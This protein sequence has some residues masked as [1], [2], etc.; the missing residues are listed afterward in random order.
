MNEIEV[1]ENEIE[2]RELERTSPI[3]QVAIELGIKVRGNMGLC[4]NEGR[5]HP[6]GEEMTL[7]FNTA[8]NSFFCKTCRDLG[9]SVIDLVSQNRKFSREEAI[10]WLKHRREFDTLT[11]ERYGS[12]G[13]KKQ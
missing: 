5:R 6:P 2:V 9:G 10:A 3:I 8:R 1:R 12:K 4:F 11:K 13:R 7:F